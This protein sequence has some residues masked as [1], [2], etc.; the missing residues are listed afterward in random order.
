MKQKSISYFRHRAIRHNAETLF[1]AEIVF[2]VTIINSD[3]K[4]VPVRYVAST[5]RKTVE[6]AFPRWQTGYRRY[7]PKPGW[8]EVASLQEWKEKARKENRN[9]FSQR[10]LK[11]AH[12]GT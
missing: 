5:L 4:K 9:D 7:R 8:R 1:Q 11:E 10:K 6:V 12:C 3:G 2:G